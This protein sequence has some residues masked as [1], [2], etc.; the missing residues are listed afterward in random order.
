M[1]TRPPRA[2][3]ILRSYYHTP[4]AAV[5]AAFPVVLRAGHLRAAADYAIER[6]S[7]PGHDLLF[8]VAGAGR[9]RV[10]NRIFSVTK[11]ELVW[12]DGYEP[13]AHWAD[14]LAPWEL[15]WLR[16]DG[17]GLEALRTLLGADEDPVFRSSDST[18]V[19]GCFREILH[20]MAGPVMHREES[21]Y[22]IVA[23]LVA[24][25]RRFRQTSGGSSSGVVPHEMRIV[26]ERM[27]LYPH[28][29]WTADELA[30]LGGMSVAR[31]YRR[32]RQ[33]T[34]S[35][36]VDWLRR[37]RISLAKRRLLESGDSIKAVAE[38]VG[39]NSPFFFSRDFKRYAGQ[40][41]TQFRRHERNVWPASTGAAART[42]R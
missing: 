17:P 28:R 36:P 33:I 32:F 27:A 3:V 15:L 22:V 1:K 21:V 35:A 13:H 34:G 40:S 42:I 6:R 11:G 20:L 8:C 4:G 10:R 24:I 7:S 12:I 19:K 39:Y 30:R 38:Q 31:F 29:H 23:Q 14:P 18:A 9:V 37:E 2:T 16:M 41:P 26:I 5:R 25:L